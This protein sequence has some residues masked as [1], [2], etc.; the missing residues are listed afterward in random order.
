M[1]ITTESKNRTAKRARP[2][3]VNITRLA[4]AVLTGILP[5]LGKLKPDVALLTGN[6]EAEVVAAPG[7]FAGGGVGFGGG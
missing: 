7:G 1:R 5:S 2:N 3:K 4:S 6:E